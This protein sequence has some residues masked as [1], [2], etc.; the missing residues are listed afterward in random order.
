MVGPRNMAIPKWILHPSLIL[1]GG[2]LIMA[3]VWQDWKSPVA[4][5]LPEKNL[6]VLVEAIA[7][8]GS[9]KMADIPQPVHLNDIRFTNPDAAK[10][11]IMKK[12][13][14]GKLIDREKAKTGMLA[15]PLAVYDQACF[16][17]PPSKQPPQPTTAC[18]V[19][20]QP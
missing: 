18:P 12:F 16:D 5:L 2:G 8:D 11:A 10:K 14:K 1:A 3:L 13:F 20:L 7:E 17:A 15:L 4:T 19:W 9:L 6:L